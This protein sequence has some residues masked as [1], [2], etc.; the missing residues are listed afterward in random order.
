M[1]DKKKSSDLPRDE[2]GKL[3]C[4]TLAGQ[5]RR[6]CEELKKKE[7]L[8]EMPRDEKGDLNC[9]PLSGDKKVIC[10]RQKASDYVQKSV[11]MKKQESK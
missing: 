11:G 1:E 3:K 4:D 7:Q 5:N 6:A 8:D 9:Q 10:T 2:K